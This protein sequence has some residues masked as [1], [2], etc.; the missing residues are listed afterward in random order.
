VS[1]RIV[2]HADESCLGNGRPGDT[3]G[4]AGG[5]I[6][7]ARASGVSRRDYFLH[8]GNTTNNRMALRSAIEALTLLGVGKPLTLEFISDSEYLVKGMNEWMR[9]WVRR[10]WKNVKN[11]ELWQTLKALADGHDIR[12]M[13]VR[14]HNLHAK[15]EYANFLA[16]RAASEQRSSSGLATSGFLDWLELEKVKGNY[17]DYD[18]DLLTA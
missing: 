10:D 2:I 7:I 11:P 6:E 16:T 5:L 14:G 1:P 8:E 3:P 13:W 15:N 4:G 17:R 9:G 18:P 12:W